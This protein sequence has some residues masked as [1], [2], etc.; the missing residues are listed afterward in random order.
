MKPQD[1]VAF[2]PNIPLAHHCILWYTNPSDR[3]FSAES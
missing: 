2:P 1:V 3:L